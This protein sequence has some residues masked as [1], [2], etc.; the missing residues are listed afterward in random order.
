MQK[1]T[2]TVF[3]ALLTLQEAFAQNGKGNEDKEI[4]LSEVIVI[5]IRAQRNLKSV[6]IAVQMVTVEDTRKS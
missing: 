1:I 3:I 2:I 5:A 4:K 6:P